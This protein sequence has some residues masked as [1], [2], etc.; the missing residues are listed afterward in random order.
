MDV[1]SMIEKTVEQKILP[2]EGAEA[3]QESGEVSLKDYMR[4]VL[5]HL[6]VICA[7]FVVVVTAV[8]IHTFRLKPVFRAT[9]R[10]NI[11]R[12]SP[13][14][15][16]IQDLW[17]F[18]ATQR[19]YMETQYKLIASKHIAQRAF[20]KLPD[21]EKDS[22]KGDKPVEAFL[23]GLVVEP[24]KDTFLVDVSYEGSD[25]KKIASW[26]NRI[27][28]EYIDYHNM[29]KTASSIEVEKKISDE[30]PKIEKKL[31]DSEGELLKFQEENEILSFDD[32]K[33]ILYQNL[34]EY[35]SALRAIIRERIDI[36]VQFNTIEKA[37][38]DKIPLDLVPEVQANKLLQQLKIDI[39]RMEQEYLVHKE[40]YSLELP[41][42]KVVKEKMELLRRQFAEEVGNVVGEISE[43][44]REIHTRESML[45]EQR[46]AVRAQIRTLQPKQARYLQ[47]SE[48]VKQNRKIYNDY[49]EHSKQLTVA[50]SVNLNEISL[51]DPADPPTA[52]VKPNR[53]L[54]VTMAVLVGLLGGIGLAFFLE[55][56]DDS[57]KG[58]E[59]VERYLRT[60]LLGV[61]PRFGRGSDDKSRDL[62][63]IREPKSTI[64]EMFRSAR[65][66]ILFSS[67]R[68]E[69]RSL[70]IW[71][72][73][74]G[75]GKTMVAVNLGVTMAQSKS[76]TLV[77]DADL[78]RPRLHK[79][80]DMENVAGL[81]TYLTGQGEL[82]GLLKKTEIENLFILP[83]GP[84]PPDP[85]E[86]LGSEKMRSLVP[87]L[88]ERFDRI[89]IDSAPAM[90]VTDAALLANLVDGIIQVIAASKVSRKLLQHGIEQMTKVG[91]AILGA[92]LNKLKAQKGGYYYSG[93]YYT[94]YYGGSKDKNKT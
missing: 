77:I 26:V 74:A 22:F 45:A 82:E 81:S 52:P 64:S 15:N 38:K 1:Q 29:Q 61:V 8:T 2:P 27:V 33:E 48:T 37:K 14:V 36:E 6:W 92:I 41:R 86:L 20:D 23:S 34:A 58:P 93:Y 54:N 89:I 10:I 75:E 12:E 42:V 31:R 72:V 51:V 85:S 83:A 90:V 17:N 44:F 3:Q 50:T 65:T 4:I 78:R 87:L 5:K 9:A 35:E 39:S 43:R 56:I 62:V 7:F 59:D 18:Y 76:R 70:L 68:G 71:S 16:K 32:E 40:R 53:L 80:F 13:S 55:Y 21:S 11:R 88:L 79:S 73:G 25:P 24:I 49:S 47:L 46:D 19:E 67:A 57:V 84:S 60:P 30:M 91:G 28:Q 94:G 63:S 66:G 69:P